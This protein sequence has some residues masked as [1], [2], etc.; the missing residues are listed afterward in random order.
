MFNRVKIK[1]M[2]EKNLKNDLEIDLEQI[3]KVC[4]VLNFE[5]N[6]EKEIEFQKTRIEQLANNLTDVTI[7]KR[8]T[9]LALGIVVSV[10]AGLLLGFIHSQGLI[11]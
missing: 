5:Y 1:E 7:R 3:K 8:K 2:H 10:C 9:W 4:E 6:E 11:Y